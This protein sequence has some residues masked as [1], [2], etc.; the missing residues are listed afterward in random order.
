MKINT[1]SSISANTITRRIT[2]NTPSFGEKACVPGD[3]FQLSA[4]C[5][6]DKPKELLKMVKSNEN[7]GNV[8]ML[9]NMILSARADEIKLLEIQKHKEESQEALSCAYTMQESAYLS[10]SIT[11]EQRE[12]YLEKARNTISNTNKI[13]AN[14]ENYREPDEKKL[15]IFGKIAKIL[16]KNPRFNPNGKDIRGNSLIN[17]AII[18]GDD[19]IA[20]M[21]IKHKKF[22]RPNSHFMYPEDYLKFLKLEKKAKSWF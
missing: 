7:I 1:I 11:D 9:F 19:E 13:M 12:K 15:K 5:Y 22:E 14:Y 18:S 17:N 16:V 3:E 10:T 21:L 2:Q 4:L 6:L 20:I 8:D